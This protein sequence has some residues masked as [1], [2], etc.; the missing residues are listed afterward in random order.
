LQQSLSKHSVAYRGLQLASIRAYSS[1]PV[2]TIQPV[3]KPVVQPDWQPAVSCKQTSN[4]LSNRLS[5]GFDNR[6]N[7]Y[8][9]DTTGCQTG[10]ITGLTTGCI[11]YT[12]HLPG[13]QTGLTTGLQ[14]VVS[15]KR[16]F[17]HCVDHCYSISLFSICVLPI[18][19]RWIKIIKTAGARDGYVP[20]SI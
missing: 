16:G 14:Q 10:L 7:V 1:Y 8:I 20:R 19:F 2:Y 3:L 18:V 5:N 12:K 6:L 15:C 9:H 17:T 4:R 11:V 13:C